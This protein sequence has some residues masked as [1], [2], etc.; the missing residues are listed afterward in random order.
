M[1][2]QHGAQP[3]QLGLIGDQPAERWLTQ[4]EAL[5]VFR[6]HGAE[7]ALLL[8]RVQTDVIR[9]RISDRGF[10]LHPLDVDRW[11]RIEG[12]I[13]NG[14]QRRR[15]TDSTATSVVRGTGPETSR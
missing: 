12:A 5:D 14:Q 2:H 4:D 13:A 3:T 6:Q 1:P 10:E 9:T 7:E 11:A 15:R 8:A